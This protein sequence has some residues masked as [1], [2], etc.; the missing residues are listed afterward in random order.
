MTDGT[1]LQRLTRATLDAF[2]TRG[3]ALVDVTCE[4]RDRQRVRLDLAGQR[5]HLVLDGAAPGTFVLEL[6]DALH[7]D[8][9]RHPGIL[10]TSVVVA[11]ELHARLQHVRFVF[12]DAASAQPIR[13]A[14][15]APDEVRCEAPDDARTD[16]PAHARID[17]PGEVRTGRPG[18]A[19][20]E[21]R[22]DPLLH[23]PTIGQDGAPDPMA[24]TAA[25]PDV[26]VSVHFST[27]LFETSAT[28]WHA[29]FELG[30]DALLY[31]AARLQHELELAGYHLVGPLDP[32]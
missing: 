22:D 24:G 19:R 7:L 12:S 20:F 14:A 27:P 8:G 21:A 26:L 1:S 4:A 31:A 15:L 23:A 29:A 28:H 25:A 17:A 13:V 10:A 2:A 6:R 32:T 16:A 5:L 11:N 9:Q 30:L 18:D 3:L